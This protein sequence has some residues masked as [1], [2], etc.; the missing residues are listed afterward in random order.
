MAV[1]GYLGEDK[2]SSR[3]H[4]DLQSNRVRG[5]CSLYYAAGLGLPSM[6]VRLLF[7]MHEPIEPK[8]PKVMEEMIELGPPTIRAVDLGDCV[9]A[10]EGCTRTEAAARLGYP[11]KLAL[12]ADDA[13]ILGASL[14]WNDLSDGA[15]YPAGWLGREIPSPRSPAYELTEDG[16]VRRI[17]APAEHPKFPT[18]RSE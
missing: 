15:S 3:I 18:L 1:V 10:I 11:V 8:V 5:F 7:T 6:I 2:P 9:A 17:Q 16:H 13:L 4:S 12:L 14:D